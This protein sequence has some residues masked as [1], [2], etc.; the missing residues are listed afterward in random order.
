MEEGDRKTYGL[1]NTAHTEIAQ[2]LPL[3]SLPIGFGATSQGLS[4]F[5]ENEH[6]ARLQ[7][8]RDAAIMSKAG[9]I[10]ELLANTDSSYITLKDET[11]IPP[12]VAEPGSLAAAVLKFN[13]QAFSCRFSA[14]L[15]AEVPKAKSQPSSFAARTGPLQ[16]SEDH[17]EQSTVKKPRLKRKHQ[18]DADH[19]G[20]EKRAADS[21]RRELKQNGITSGI[22]E[23]LN[24]FL[25]RSDTH[26]DPDGEEE[27]TTLSLQEMKSISEEITSLHAKAAVSKIPSERL[28]KLL[29]FLDRHVRHAHLKEIDEGDDVESDNFEIVM[30]ALEAVQV[31]LM[32]MSSPKMPKQIYK[33]EVIDRIIEFTRYQIVHSVFT[34]YD[35]LYRQ[36]HKNGGD[37]DEVD[38]E[39]EDEGK[40]GRRKSRSGKAKKLTSSRVSTAV[41][42]VLHKLC[43]ILALLKDLLSVEKLLDST[44]LQL[45][46]TVLGTFG[47]DNIQL[48]QL[49]AIGVAS[50]VFNIYPQHQTVMIDELLSMLWKLPSSK[51]N[52]RTYHLPEEEH[53][54]IQMLVALLLQ[55]VQCS[56]ALP[57]LR[58]GQEKA[59]TDTRKCFEPAVSICNYFWRNVFQRWAVPKAQ[60]GSDVKLVMENLVL[61][62]LATINVPEFPAASLLLQVLCVL[63]LGPAGVKSKDVPV[64][65]SAI[66]IL[67]QIAAHLKRD[68]VA[69]SKDN[70]WILQETQ[71]GPSSFAKDVCTSCGHSKA[72]KFILRCDSC[73]RWFHGDCVGVTGQ[74]LIGRGWFCHCCLCRNQLASFD[75][76]SSGKSHDTYKVPEDGAVIV[77]QILLNFLRETDSGDNVSFFARRFYLCLWYGYDPQGLQSLAFYH[78]RWGSKAPH[79]DFGIT[80]N[81]ISRDIIVRIT[82]ALGQQ[83]PLARGFDRIL[84][85]LLASL[86]ENASNPRAKALKA[87]SAIVEVDPGVLADER[88]QKAVEGRFMDSAIS[89]REAAMELVGRHIVSRPDV[90]IKYFDRLSERIMDTGVSVRKR[91]IKILRDF[92]LLA[93][94]FPKATDACI[95]VISRINDDEASIQ[96]LVCKTFYELWFEEHPGQQ[97]QF[98][99]DGSIVPSEIA[100]RV[101]QIVD[102]LKSLPNHQ[103]I[104][105]IIKRSLTLDFIPQGSKTAAPTNISQAAVRNRCELMC[106]YLME[107]ILKAEETSEDSEVQ[108]LPYVSALH[109]F[110]IVD[111]TL[112]APASDPSRFAVTLQP[113]LKTLADNRDIAQLLQS[114]VYVIDTVLPLLRRPPQN[115]VEELERDLRQLIVRYS[116]LTVVHACIKCLASL[117]KISS[118]KGVV[119]D[120]LVRQFYKVLESWQNSEMIQEKPN[121][122]RSLFCLGLFVRY[123]AELIDGMNDHDVTMDSV[124]NLYTHYLQSE[125]FEVKVKALQ[126]AG[127]VFLARPDFMMNESIGKVLGDSLISKADTRLKMQTLRNFYEYLLDVEKQMGLANAKDG[128]SRDATTAVP[129]AAGAGDSNIC[130]GII[131]LHWDRILERCLDKDEQ[132]RQAAI[133]VVDAVLRQGLVHPMTCVPQLIAL[134][135]DQQEGISK[136][137]HRLLSNLNDKYPSFF[138]TRLGDG[139]QLSFT[140]IQ[141]G[142]THA[143]RVKN[144]VDQNEAAFARAGISRIYKLIRGSRNSRNKFLA[145]VVRKFDWITSQASTSFLMYCTEIL[146]SLP[147]NLLEEPLYLIF[148]INRILQ[149]RA[150]D[151]EAS[152]KAEFQQEPLCG[153][154]K[155]TAPDA[156]EEGTSIQV[157]QEVLKHLQVQ[158]DGAV[159]LS[160]LL[161]MK[162]HLKITFCLDDA[163]CQ[164]FQP[165]DP[166]KSAEVVSRQAAKDFDCTDIFAKQPENVAEVVQRYQLFKSLL[167]ADTMDYSAYAPPASTR[168]RGR[169][170]AAADG[171]YQGNGHVGSKLRRKSAP[172]A[173]ASD[174]DGDPDAQE[175][176]GRTPSKRRKG[177]SRKP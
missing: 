46:K 83:R 60:E 151:L 75:P 86:Q 18:H 79:Q 52:L 24:E 35:P 77:Q 53:K 177:K 92:C 70:L 42:I 63:L 170:S 62:L 36:V 2:S 143:S 64:R 37:E 87:V 19:Q 112:C 144:K 102:V 57:E 28:I 174:D 73:K 15:K 173:P 61:D 12:V 103:P 126:A 171:L 93:G 27:G 175:E 6:A 100:E 68:T 158:S 147:F 66:D 156:T 94:G 110:C 105:M 109:A 90:A 43:S 82:R 69:Y 21:G 67:G 59:S 166:V 117:T 38:E 26:G 124:L 99:A 33:E 125:D 39:E 128:E 25:E 71:E 32:I 4:L 176:H 14:P 16:N 95:R 154:M 123:G 149:V 22:C 163:R 50:M 89:V 106:K 3:P 161:K 153:L 145:S 1:A 85:R 76:G 137:A 65:V 152:I 84:E 155:Q 172:P 72:N 80:S 58:T 142:A 127:F 8:A 139:L 167:K 17:E 116:F 113:Y 146:V 148:A 96:D 131:Q 45:M 107:C 160:L 10:A 129:I 168:K 119:F 88:V 81:A 108:A 48:L 101:Q 157:P 141:T 51:K 115:L 55:L 20:K 98:V 132:V 9:K 130:G 30:T 34:A 104:V 118:K 165:S 44:I 5:E 114:I 74:D 49:K 47:V 54:Q 138:E 159:A 11:S 13:P 162:R 150:G 91:V 140:F 120:F 56:V 121:I 169:S 164:A 40:R 135:V 122:L 111:P 97:T 41:S 29:N 136:L 78:W 133:K 31:T 7:G 23:L 134:E